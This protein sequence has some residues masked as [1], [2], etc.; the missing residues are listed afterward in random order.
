LA[1]L[2]IDI[3]TT[4]AAIEQSD[5]TLAT[6]LPEIFPIV[7][8][9]LPLYTQPSTLLALAL[10]DHRLHEIVVPRLLYQ[11][12]W[13]EGEKRALQVLRSLKTQAGAIDEK[14]FLQGDEMPIAHHIH[15]LCISSE[16]SKDARETKADTISELRELIDIGGL[17]NL[18]SLALHMGDGWYV[19]YTDYER[20][21]GFGRLD[22]LF[23]T[24]LQ[25]NCPHLKEISLTG[26]TDY[27]DDRWVEESG[28]YE[29]Q[30][31][32]SSSHT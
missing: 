7:A 6:L 13:L 9:H 25:D 21:T 16:L 29:Y 10:T 20:V 12:V 24:S 22:K 30:V 19:D 26:V 15:R 27:R 2:G 3:E 14:A 28:L 23:W 17:R 32:S 11:K 18:V 31:P 4:M 1:N 8:A 5:S